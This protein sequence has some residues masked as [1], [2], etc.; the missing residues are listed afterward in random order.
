MCCGICGVEWR[1][2][3]RWEVGRGMRLLRKGRGSCVMQGGRV[4]ED[5]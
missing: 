2:G 4:R 5:Y 3:F 1:W